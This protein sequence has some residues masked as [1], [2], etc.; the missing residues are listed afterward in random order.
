MALAHSAVPTHHPRLA[1]TQGAVAQRKLARKA[2][3]LL[4]PAG[5]SSSASPWLHKALVASDGAPD[6]IRAQI[7]LLSL[8]F[9]EGMSPEEAMARLRSAAEEGTK[10]ERLR[11]RRQAAEEKGALEFDS[12]SDAV[13]RDVEFD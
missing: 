12:Y 13:G 10:T 7:V 5:Q 1:P 6:V 4:A 11:A 8:E 2:R 9:A 3:P